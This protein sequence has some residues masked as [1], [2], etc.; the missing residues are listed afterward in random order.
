M[1]PITTFQASFGP[2]VDNAAATPL[3]SSFPLF[4]T[5]L[6]LMAWFT[7]RKKRKAATEFAAALS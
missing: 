7:P 3:T 1:K 2:S 5:G 6:G 4:A